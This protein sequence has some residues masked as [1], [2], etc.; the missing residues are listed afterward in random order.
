VRLEGKVTKLT[1]S[2]MRNHHEKHK[3]YLYKGGLRGKEQGEI[4][5]EAMNK[6]SYVQ[7]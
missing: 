2:V 5:K 1:R 3:K 7:I 4:K 6:K